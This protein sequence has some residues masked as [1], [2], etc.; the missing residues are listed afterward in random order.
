MCCGAREGKKGGEGKTAEGGDM[1]IRR[2]I[3]ADGERER[4]L[5]YNMNIM[6]CHVSSLLCVSVSVSVDRCDGQMSVR[7]GHCCSVKN[8]MFLNVS[9][10]TEQHYAVWYTCVC[11]ALYTCVTTHTRVP[12]C[13]FVSPYVTFYLKH[14]VGAVSVVFVRLTFS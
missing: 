7:P 2:V 13:L 3:S 4:G 12:M 8:N 9:S 11:M 6:C 1:L 10:R 5:R 14:V